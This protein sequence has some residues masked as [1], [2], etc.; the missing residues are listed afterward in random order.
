MILIA[1]WTRKKA[2]LLDFT[3][4]PDKTSTIEKVS[5]IGV[6]LIGQLFFDSHFTRL[7]RELV[8]R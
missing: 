6:L 7:L 5:V 2:R 3:N 4:W 1:F 8:K